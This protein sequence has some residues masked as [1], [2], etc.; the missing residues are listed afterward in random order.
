MTTTVTTQELIEK[1]AQAFSDY[2]DND[3]YVG[4]LDFMTLL[5]SAAKKLDEQDRKLNLCYD[6]IS[7]MTCSDLMDEIENIK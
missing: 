6:H 4:I 5:I 3:K 7:S 1:I 2:D